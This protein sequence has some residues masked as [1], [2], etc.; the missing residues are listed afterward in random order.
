MESTTPPAGGTTP[1]APAPG[2]Q[3]LGNGGFF[4]SVRRAGVVRTQDRWI[5][6]VCG[7]IARRL[8]LD[9]LLVRG[10]VAVTVLL[11]GAG[12]VLYGVA[13]ALLPEEADGRIHLEETIRGRFDAALLGAIAVVVV[14]LNR[15]DGWFGWWNDRGLGWINGLLWA[16]ALAAVI[17]LVIAAANQR[18]QAPAS[19]AAPA[20]AV[21]G[22]TGWSGSTAARS[23]STAARSGTP[24]GKVPHPGYGA[25]PLTHPAPGP[26]ASGTASPADTYASG[27]PGGPA[28]DPSATADTSDWSR[29]PGTPGTPGQSG[30]AGTPDWS[31]TAGT[32]GA[33]G[34]LLP[35]PPPSWTAG[36]APSA[37]SGVPGGPYGPTPPRAAYPV[38]P[39]PPRPAR[40]RV[41]GPGVGA[42]G[43]V[44]GLTLLTL[45]VLLILQREGELGDLPVGLTAVGI[46]VVLTGLAIMIA[47]LR[48]RSS[49][50][51]GFL[52]IVGIVAAVP[53]A[54][55]PGTV[56][57]F[58]VVGG[59]DGLRVSSGETWTP[60]SAAEAE[61][62]I[63]IG[64]GDL[65]VDLTE[66]PLDD[67]PVEVPIRMSAGNLLVV[68][69]D[70]AAVTG[71]VALT[72]GEFRWDVDP[73][74]D[75][76]VSSGFSGL[77]DGAHQPYTSEE[78][79]DAD[80]QLAVRIT[81]GAGD[82]RVVEENR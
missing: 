29:T 71:D 13:W 28:A 20:G 68:V 4:N 72:V 34:T 59:P 41:Q 58:G 26:Y 81:A 21:P 27:V 75:R 55:V 43:T 66:V 46:G 31:G 69:P 7:G 2:P 39:T 56:D 12:L 61:R 14:G 32:S 77:T 24:T 17:A 18:G 36:P 54:L 45:A 48:G 35:P 33:S 47:G 62:G 79:V 44:V 73:E 10:L 37:S 57:R 40:R 82:V 53:V 11:G 30:T 65:R 60:R 1:P 38:P 78:A 9:P 67:E 15:G 51:L 23:Q 74:S 3:D 8:G 6:G 42:V 76:G 70:D 5:G 63:S 50:T 19:G 80:V 16:A 25:V 52:G 49:G 64:F 22:G